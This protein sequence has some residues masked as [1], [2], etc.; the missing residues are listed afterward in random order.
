M[1]LKPHRGTVPLNGTRE[2]DSNSFLF[3]EP[4]ERGATLCRGLSVVYRSDMNLF[5]R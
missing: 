5:S 4:A 3:A 2:N 1:S